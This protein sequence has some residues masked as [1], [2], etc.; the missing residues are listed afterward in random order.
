MA[1]VSVPLCSLCFRT[2]SLW[3]STSWSSDFNWLIRSWIRLLSTSSFVS[4][5]PLVP[6]PP[7][8]LDREF[9]SPTRRTA[10]YLNCASSTWIFPSLVFA[11]AAKISRMIIVR[12]MTFVSRASSRFFNCAGE[13]SSSQ[14]TPVAPDSQ[15]ISFNSWILPFPRYVPGWIFSRFWITT[16]TVSAPAV[17]TS[18]RSSSTDS[19]VSSEAFVLAANRMTRSCCSPISINSA[20]LSP[21]LS[22]ETRSHDLPS[23]PVHTAPRSFG[24]A[25]APSHTGPGT[26]N[27]RPG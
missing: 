16:P 7:P 2:T 18:S 27:T 11:R 24:T 6:I 20:I 21:I 13:S 26:H 19:S 17:F 5:G 9:L 23:R 14:T 1:A 22:R 15:T 25:P 12:S 3:R 4:P 10:R 8:S